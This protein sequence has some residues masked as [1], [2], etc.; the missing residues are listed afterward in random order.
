MSEPSAITG[1]PEP[2][3]AMNAVG[4]PAMPS[5]TV[6]PF[7]LSTSTRYRWVSNLLEAELAEAEDGIDH[8]LGED[9]HR[10]DVLD[11]IGLEALGAGIILRPGASTG[12]VTAAVPAGAVAGDGPDWFWASGAAVNARVTARAGITRIRY[13]NDAP[14][15]VGF[16]ARG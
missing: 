11:R 1:L 14:D 8:L 2:H 9:L 12:A 5:C 4:M 15:A 10:L 16:K 3:V 13:M 6:K 7:F